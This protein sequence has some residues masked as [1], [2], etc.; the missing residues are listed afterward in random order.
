ML[1]KLNIMLSISDKDTH[2]VVS[3]IKRDE[4]GKIEFFVSK[5][6]YVV[7][8]TYNRQPTANSQKGNKKHIMLKEML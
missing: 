6:W 1:N 4:K 7:I 5:I 3:F 2:C 8:R